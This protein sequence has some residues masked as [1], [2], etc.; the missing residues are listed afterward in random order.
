MFVC[1]Y[2]RVCVC[3]CQCEPCIYV[4]V[5]ISVIIVFTCLYACQCDPCIYVFVCLR[6]SMFVFSFVSCLSVCLSVLHTM[7]ACLCGD[8]SLYV[9]KDN[10]RVFDCVC[11]VLTCVGID[12]H[13]LLKCMHFIMQII[14]D[15]INRRLTQV[16]NYTK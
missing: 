7:L 9:N 1:V 11:L 10:I 14:N 5:C 13:E 8:I 2:L 4:F 16:K 6:V 3:M 15:V 12:S